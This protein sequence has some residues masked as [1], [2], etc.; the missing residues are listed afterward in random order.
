MNQY[1][2]R[3]VI[4]HWLT[5]VLMIA[6]WFLGEEVHDARK[7]E[8]G[9]TV[10][11]YVAHALAG[12]AVLLL[13]VLRLA[14][15]KADGVPAPIGRS[16]MDKIATGVHHSLYLLLFLLPVSGMVQ[17]MTSDVGKAILAGDATLLPRKF[18]GVMAHEVHEILVTVV[19]LLVGVHVLGAL[20]HQ[21]VLKDGLL[22]RMWFK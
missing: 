1:S 10:A 13:T 12:A 21:F 22:K 18:D 19:I 7:A 16:T 20:K 3:M 4:M 17:V 2:N 9:A 11:G 8:A 14:F 6:A 15:R 5:L